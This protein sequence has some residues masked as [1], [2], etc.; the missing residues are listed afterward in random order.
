MSESRYSRLVLPGYFLASLLVI[1]PIVDIVMISLPLEFGE[2]QWRFG[3][4]GTLTRAANTPLLGIVIA[5]MLAA[6]LGHRRRLRAMSAFFVVIFVVALVVTILF[7][8]DALQVRTDFNPQFQRPFD[9][10][11]AVGM[12]KLIVGTALFGAFGFIGWGLSRPTQVASPSD[13]RSEL[14]VGS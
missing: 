5:F 4:F 1:L 12:L 8:L 9:R 6:M 10:V 13:R 11:M 3:F 7:A 2:V 14:V